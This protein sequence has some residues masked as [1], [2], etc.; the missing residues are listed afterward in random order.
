MPRAAKRPECLAGV[1]QSGN[2]WNFFIAVHMLLECSALADLNARLPQHHGLF[3]VMAGVEPAHSYVEAATC[4]QVHNGVCRQEI[5]LMIDRSCPICS[6]LSTAWAVSAHEIHWRV[7]VGQVVTE[8]YDELVFNEPTEAFHS[9]F[10]AHDPG[11]A[12]D[13]Q[14]APFFLAFEPQQD[15]DK[16]NALRRRIAQQKA[17]LLQQFE[18]PMS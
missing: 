5:V 13:S 4:Q 18:A 6:G 3:G 14:A 11:P 10:T 9:S 8:T 1:Q 16:I 15:L 12:K 17:G 2:G 7:C